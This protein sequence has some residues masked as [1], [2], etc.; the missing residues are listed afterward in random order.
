MVHLKH[1]N[2]ITSDDYFICLDPTCNVVYFSLESETIFNTNDIN[3]PIWYK[4]NAE[5]KYA[6]YCNKVTVEE[7]ISVINSHSCTSIKDLMKYTQVMI[8]GKCK[9]THP[10]GQCCSTELNKLIKENS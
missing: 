4:E 3:T 1:K 10:K 9:T 2:L 8:N 7:V 5:I 6:C